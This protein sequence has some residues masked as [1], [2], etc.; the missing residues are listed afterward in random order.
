MRLVEQ[1]LRAAPN[2]LIRE[3]GLIPRLAKHLVHSRE[4]PGFE[5]RLRSRP[6]LS[7]INQTRNTAIPH[8]S[9]EPFHRPLTAPKLS[10]LRPHPLFHTAI[11]VVI[12]ARLIRQPARWVAASKTS[13]DL[14]DMGHQLLRSLQKMRRD[15]GNRGRRKLTAGTRADVDRVGHRQSSQRR[16]HRLSIPITEKDDVPFDGEHLEN[17]PVDGHVSADV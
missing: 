17:D 9:A 2:L 14:L 15:V 10:R 4:Y 3:R 13:L 12:G 7:P 1:P 6:C 11:R 8:R 16:P 5:Y